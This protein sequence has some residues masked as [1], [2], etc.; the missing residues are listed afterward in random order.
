MIPNFLKFFK[1]LQ[2]FQG[3]MKKIQEEL[4]SEKVTGTSG[5]GMIEVVMSGKLEVIDIKIEKKLL[6]RK[7][8]QMLQDLI[9]AAVNDAIKK[10]QGKIGEKFGEVTGGLGLSQF[11]IPGM[12]NQNQ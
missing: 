5:A 9:V 8:I 6:E 3:E 2:K 12:F 1:D 7:N 4:A 10:A 11:D